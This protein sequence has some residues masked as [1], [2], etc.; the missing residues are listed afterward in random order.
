MNRKSSIRGYSKAMIDHTVGI[1]RDDPMKLRTFLLQ[2]RMLSS[3]NE[4]IGAQNLLAQLK[5]I[6]KSSS[7]GRSS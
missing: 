2:K 1:S 4:F 6:I 3:S 5:M 7:P